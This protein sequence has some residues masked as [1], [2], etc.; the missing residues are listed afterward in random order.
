MGKSARVAR[1]HARTTSAAKRVRPTLDYPFDGPPEAGTA[2]E[3]APGV[4]WIR[5]PLPF[6]LT[7]INLWAIADEDERGPGWAIVDTGT[8]LPLISFEMACRVV[9]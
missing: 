4:L 9:Y 6:T 2:R 1:R 8:Q 3:V 7:H 5:M